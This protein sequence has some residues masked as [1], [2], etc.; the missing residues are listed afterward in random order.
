M[1]VMP[2]FRCASLLALFHVEQHDNVVYSL[3]FS[4]CEDLHLPECVSEVQI[5]NYLPKCELKKKVFVECHSKVYIL[6]I[7]GCDLFSDIYL[8]S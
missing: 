7:L 2:V 5:E 6:P 1:H 8:I 3:E 4:V